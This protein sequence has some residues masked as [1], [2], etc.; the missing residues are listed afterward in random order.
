MNLPIVIRKY[1][2]GDRGAC[3]A[4]WRELTE[5]HR[6]IYQ[7]PTIGGEHPEDHFDKHLEEVGPDQIWVA[8][9]NS[10][11]IGLIGLIVEEKEGEIEPI[12]IKRAFRKKGIGKQLI[13]RIIS[14]VRSRGIRFLKV[15]PVARNK[16]AMKFFYE[17][18]FKNLGHI[19][20]FMDLSD[21]KRRPWKVG[22]EI[23][24]CRFCF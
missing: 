6:E 24:G 16:A 22:P 18:G 9:H 4:L 5:W 17:R 15:K 2:R 11:I 13:E 10:Q 14:E 23:S 1:R 7:D 19:E 3:R 12:I 20:M 21:S 8:V